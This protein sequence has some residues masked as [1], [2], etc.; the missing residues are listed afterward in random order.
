MH[1]TR[2]TKRENQESHEDK[3][4]HERS[5][6]SPKEQLLRT[7]LRGDLPHVGAR[8]ALRHACQ[9]LDAQC[10]T[11]HWR[12]PELIGGPPRPIA[13][14]SEA[15]HGTMELGQVHPWADEATPERQWITR[16]TSS[17]SLAPD[18][19]LCKVWEQ[20]LYGFYAVPLRSRGKYLGWLGFYFA[21]ETHPAR[22]SNA[23]V[24]EI[25][26]YFSN[27]LRRHARLDGQAM[28]HEWVLQSLTRVTK[29]FVGAHLNQTD[30]MQGF[31]EEVA[32]SIGDSCSVFLLNNDGDK[33]RNV[34]HATRMMGS[35]SPLAFDEIPSVAVNDEHLVAQCFRSGERVFVPFAPTPLLNVMLPEETHQSEAVRETAGLLLY[36]LCVQNRILGVVSL[37]RGAGRARFEKQDLD[38][39]EQLAD[40]AALAVENMRAFQEELNARQSAS[41]ANFWLELRHDAFS[42]LSECHTQAQVFEATRHA[43]T[44]A[45][46]HVEPVFWDAQ[47]GLLDGVAKAKAPWLHAADEG[48]QE[49]GD[50]LAQM[51][52]KLHAWTPADLCR[53]PPVIQEIWQAGWQCVVLC[54]LKDAERSLGFCVLPGLHLDALADDE[55]RYLQSVQEKCASAWS[56]IDLVER[57]RRRKKEANELAKLQTQLM[58]VVGHD[59]RNPLAAIRMGA[60]LLQQ[61]LPADERAMR[62]LR[63]VTRTAARA[64]GLIQQLMDFS[65]VRAGK[66]IPLQRTTGSARSWLTEWVEEIKLSHPLRRVVIDARGDV[67]VHWDRDRMAQAVGNLLLNALHHSDRDSDVVVGLNSDGS[68]VCFSVRNRGPTITRAQ[69]ERLFEPFERGNTHEDRGYGLGLYI[70]REVM[71]AHGGRIQVSSQDNETCFVSIVPSGTQPAV[72]GGLADHA[73]DVTAGADAT[74]EV[75]VLGRAAR[76]AKRVVYAGAPA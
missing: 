11:L 37:T 50:T 18:F 53:A 13:H 40:H 65:L 10:A 64:E 25:G 69:C 36:P 8:A 63:R 32:T 66:G 31:A 55:L 29:L 35:Q 70:V 74:E 72:G 23:L 14:H 38:W 6:V 57:L 5:A 33:L 49:H 44:R 62:L 26:L 76:K 71:C 73:V 60:A 30:P 48:S 19:P 34:A 12:P 45:F 67:E 39:L 43:I 27:A 42:A 58:G 46:P 54:P 2:N 56:H 47:K 75:F 3:V 24:D 16:R 20:G 61:M 52:G 4:A 22:V 68:N 51:A 1:R 28:R 21:D 7:L 59:L 15:G 9:L 17:S 41:R